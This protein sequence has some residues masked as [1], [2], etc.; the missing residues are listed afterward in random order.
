MKYTLIRGA[1]CASLLITASGAAHATLIS[2]AGG[3]AYYDTVAD[4]TWLAD[5]NYALTSGYVTDGPDGTMNWESATLWAA[6]LNI[7]GEYGWRLPTTD[8]TDSTCSFGNGYGNNCTGSEMGNLFYNVLG[9]TPGSL[10]NSGP[11]SNIGA[12]YYW[13]STPYAP[14]RNAA[15]VFGMGNGYQGFD[16]S[17]IY[18]YAWAVKTGDVFAAVVP[19]PAAAWLFGS[20]LLGLIGVARRKKSS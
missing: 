10:T 17:G 15:W 19:V 6:H 3:L 12:G 9:N 4:L 5:A 13:S 16:S 14:Q 18:H 20:G 1:L 2:R 11:F 7:A 8:T